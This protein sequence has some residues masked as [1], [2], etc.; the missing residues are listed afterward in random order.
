MSRTP[1]QPGATAPSLGA[2]TEAVLREI[3]ID[4]DEFVA[5]R[6]QGTI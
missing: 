3:G 4:E 5:L 1:L 6:E 2:D